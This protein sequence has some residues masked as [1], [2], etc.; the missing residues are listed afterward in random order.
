MDKY[1]GKSNIEDIPQNFDF[2]AEREKKQTQFVKNYDN[3][4]KYLKDYK[5]TNQ[6]MKAMTLG[7]VLMFIFMV[8]IIVTLVLYFLLC[9]G[10]FRQNTSSKVSWGIALVLLIIFFCLLVAFLVFISLA[11]KHYNNVLC[12][13]LRLPGGTIYGYKTKNQGQFLGLENLNNTYAGFKEE[14]VVV[15]TQGTDFSQ[16]RNQN[17]RSQASQLTVSLEDFKDFA[18]TQTVSNMNN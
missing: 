4:L 15:N 12:T 18:L 11:Q 6:L 10:V 1:C 8:V 7:V 3:V 2:E 9:C 14:L 13:A 17:F 16:I 5:N